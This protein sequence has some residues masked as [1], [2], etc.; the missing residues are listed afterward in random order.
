MRD[1][2]GF[3]FLGMVFSLLL[4]FSITNSALAENIR[5]GVASPFTGDLAAYGDNIK[6]GVNLKIGRAVSIDRGKKVCQTDD[7]TDIA[8]EKLVLATG[9]MPVVPKWLKGAD[10]TNV[11]AI[12]KNKVYLAEMIA[13]LS[14]CRKIVTV[15]GGFIGVEVSDELTKRGKEVT[16]VEILPNILG[17]A[18]DTEFAVEAERL[19]EEE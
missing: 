17:L 10:L 13:K 7:G 9:S 6:A 8:F 12:H 14:D 15:G 16:L 4:V 11:F 1:K 18:F 5:I 2:R 3:V 19:L